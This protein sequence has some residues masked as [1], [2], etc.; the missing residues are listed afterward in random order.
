MRDIGLLTGHYSK[1]VEFCNDQGLSAID[2]CKAF[3]YTRQNYVGRFCSV[4]FWRDKKSVAWLSVGSNTVLTVG[5]LVVGFA[6]GSVSILSEAAHSAIDLIAAGMATFSVHVSDRP[7]DETHQYGHEK[8]ENVSGVIEGLLIFAAAVWIIYEAVDKLVHGVELRYLSRGVAVMAISGGMNW[9]VATLLKKSAIRNRSVALEAD[10]AHLYADVYTSSGVFL[11]LAVITLARRFFGVDLSW[12]DPT[13]AIAVATLILVTAYRITRK[14]FF[15]LMDS[16]AS[17]EEM[18]KIENVIR[19]FGK[20]GVDFHKLRTRSA[21]GSLYVDLHI[22][23]KPGMSLEQGHDLSH[24]LTAKIEKTVPGA[25]VLAHLEP[26]STIENIPDQDEQIRCMRDEILRDQRVCEVNNLHATRYRGDVRVEADLSLDPK[27]SLGESRAVAMDLKMRLE[28][29]FP[30]VRETAFCLH[31]GDGWQRAFHGDDMERIRNLVGEHE[32]R[33]ANIHELEV[34]SSGGFHRVHLSLGMP[35]ALPVSEAHAVA[36]HLEADIRGL[37]PEGADIDLH[38][39]PCNEACESCHAVCP[40][41]KNRERD[42]RA[43]GQHSISKS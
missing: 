28:A 13:I 8:I 6:T 26:S 9:V 7:P 40:M 23:F 43:L 18:A 24:L 1:S 30:E 35:P 3:F 25:K 29:C 38:I 17:P 21:G 11:G 15:P 36:K 4:S 16:S 5:K 12:L 41:K 10:A 32:S 19:E 42:P 2:A 39:E 31:P 37:F 27:V 20:N 14:S 22:G 34:V 33:F